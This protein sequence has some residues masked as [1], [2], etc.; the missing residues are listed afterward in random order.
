MLKVNS[1]PIK[2]ILEPII[3]PTSYFNNLL[4]AVASPAFRFQF[5]IAKHA[6][7]LDKH[8]ARWQ[9]ISDGQVLFSKN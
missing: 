7:G 9:V 4:L 3:N 1:Y 8:T 2:I 5:F 6:T